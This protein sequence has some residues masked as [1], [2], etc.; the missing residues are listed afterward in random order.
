MKRIESTK[1]FINIMHKIT[2]MRVYIDLTAEIRSKVLDYARKKGYRLPK[3]YLE[4]IKKGLE[5]EGYEVD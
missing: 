5:A 3:A 1:N 4:L 2:F